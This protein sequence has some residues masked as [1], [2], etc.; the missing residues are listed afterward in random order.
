MVRN[1]AAKKAGRRHAV[2]NTSDA[3]MQTP[4]A[5][6]FCARVHSRHR[7][8]IEKLAEERG[9]GSARV[10]KKRLELLGLWR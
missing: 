4:G 9:L 7:R 10:G 6:S 2:R 1:V 3:Q 5:D 8:I